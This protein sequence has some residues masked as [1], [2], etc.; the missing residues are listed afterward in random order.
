MYDPVDVKL[1]VSSSVRSDRGR[2]DSPDPLLVS[3]T[4][5]DAFYLTIHVVFHFPVV[6]G[7]VGCYCKS[8]G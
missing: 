6:A 8:V 1:L 4:G 5:Y 2:P 7:C 3:T